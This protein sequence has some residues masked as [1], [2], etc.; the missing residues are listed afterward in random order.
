MTLVSS[1]S[2]SFPAKQWSRAPAL[3]PSQGGCEDK[4]SRW[5][6]EYQT[7]RDGGH[8]AAVGVHGG[9]EG[10][11]GKSH[12]GNESPGADAG[13]S[14]L[15]APRV[16]I[17]AHTTEHLHTSPAPHGEALALHLLSKSPVPLEV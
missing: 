16:L 12:P 15:H 6:G 9:E 5:E 13:G 17:V 11:P 7:E 1:A 8:L 2:D 3:T 4:V 14:P 10:R